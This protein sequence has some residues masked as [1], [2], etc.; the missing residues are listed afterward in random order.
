[1]TLLPDPVWPA[2]VLAVIAFGDCLLTFRPP[3]AIVDCLDG[4]GFPRDWWWV[5]AVV[6]FLA[7]A[8][9]VAGIWVPGLGV[10]AAVGLVVY[11]LCAAAAHL[12][13]R[14][15]GR[16]F[17]LNCLGMLIVCLAVLVFSFLG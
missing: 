1:M 10:A 2:V 14:Y 7:A 13:A 8:G 5:L 12:R 6:K 9:L 3:R 17:W 16:D 11:F 15:V 4:V